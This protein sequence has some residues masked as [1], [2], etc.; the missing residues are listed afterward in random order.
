M[1]RTAPADAVY[2]TDARVVWTPMAGYTLA[3]VVVAA[4]ETAFALM[5]LAVMVWAAIVVAVMAPA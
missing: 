5:L 4:T 3:A 1:R 2:V